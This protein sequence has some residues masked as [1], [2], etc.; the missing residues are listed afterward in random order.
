M[1]QTKDAQG[2]HWAVTFVSNLGDQPTLQLDPAPSNTAPLSGVNLRLRIEE[3]TKGRNQGHK[4]VFD[5]LEPGRDYAARAAAEN[6]VG[7]GPMTSDPS[8]DWAIEPYRAKAA[9]SPEPPQLVSA[10][11]IS[12]TS[13]QLE[14]SAPNDKGSPIQEYLIEWT[15]AT[16]FETQKVVLAFKIFNP[17][18]NDTT[19][20]FVL[21]LGGETTVPIYMHDVTGLQV[22]QAVEA[23]PLVAGAEVTQEALSPGSGGHGFAWTITVTQKSAAQS[24]LAFGPGAVDTSGLRSVCRC[25]IVKWAFLDST[26]FSPPSL[27]ENYGSE[28]MHAACGGT[29]LGK[30]SPYQVV[31]IVASERLERGGFRLSL[32][33]ATTPCLRVDSTAAEVRAALLSSLGGAAR[34]VSVQGPRRGSSGNTTE[35]RVRFEGAHGT[36]SWPTLAPV[37]GQDGS[38]GSW[39]CGPWQ[40]PGTVT[41]STHPFAEE[42]LCLGGSAAA[43]AVV[44]EARSPLGGSL[45]WVVSGQVVHVPVAASGRQAEALLNR[46]LDE[47]RAQGATA[48]G[49]AAS[50]AGGVRVTRL[51]VGGAAFGAAWLVEYPASRGAV[52]ALAVHGEALTG[53]D[54]TAGAYPV[55]NVFSS[56]MRND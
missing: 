4:A 25:G 32:D 1:S 35:F 39:P 18:K 45:E 13:V 36:G 2:I 49:T 47:G 55:A 40:A 9:A 41:V 8:T 6:S 42:G 5:G 34:G 50:S 14:F 7:I 10:R 29:V 53:G 33:G 46:A 20:F 30:A 23:L 3:T 22:R 38:N 21:T 28:V 19:G 16:S 37:L 27:P 12:A 24:S 31:S 48:V 11:N 17:V 52:P 44:V 56:S 43:Q 15:T 26:T 51:G 54:A